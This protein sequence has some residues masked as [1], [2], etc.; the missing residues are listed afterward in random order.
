MKNEMVT[1]SVI[2]LVIAMSILWFHVG[3]RQ[4]E[5]FAFDQYLIHAHASKCRRNAL[6]ML[7]GSIKQTPWD[8][9]TLQEKMLLCAYGSPGNKM[10]QEDIA[11]IGEVYGE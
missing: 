2:V 6:A 1:V 8:E 11:R 3:Y 7:H 10:S 9:F 5:E 4:A